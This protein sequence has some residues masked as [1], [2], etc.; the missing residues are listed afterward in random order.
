MKI[1]SG[2][3]IIIAAL[4]ISIVMPFSVSAAPSAGI[5]PSSIFYFFDTATERVSLFFTFSPEKKA[6]KALEYADERLA[7]VVADESKPKA[8]T[9]AMANYQENIS[10]ATAESKG[11]KDKEKA[12]SLLS[13]IANS[14]SK[15]QEV[16]AK[17][18]N[19]VPDEAK[20]AIEKAIE[21]SIKG[22]E[23]ALKE[24]RGLKKTVEELQKD[25]ETL[26]QHGQSAQGKEI[27]VLRK[28]VETLKSQQS[29]QS[30]KP[31]V[32][33]KVIEKIIEV[34]PTTS[35]K[36]TTKLSNSEIIEKVKPAVVYIQT[37]DGSG[38][39]MII[40]SNGYVLTNAHVVNDVNTAK[41]KLSDGRLF[42]G[43]VT[44]RDEK[45]D[46]ALLKIQNDNL[47]VVVLGDSSINI[48]KQGDEVFTLG[49][50]FGLE[51]DV[52]FKEGTIS[53]RI[54]DSDTT[55][56]ETSAEIHPGNSGG[57]LVNKY[58]EV[59]GINTANYGKSIKGIAIGE[60]IKFALP[61]NLVRGLI[62]EL[63]TGRNVV[64]PTAPTTQPIPAPTP[65][66]SP[67]TPQIV[68]LE[69]ISAGVVPDVTSARIEWQTN[70]P[71]NAKIFISGKVY[72]SESGL[73]TRHIVNA[74]DLTSNTT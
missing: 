31:Q 61:I 5:K 10:L 2:K 42:I 17:V 51:G 21:I 74:K 68:A 24:A 52:S 20:K 38:S 25:I 58:G 29:T 23:E 11:I 3:T 66:L 8:V 30:A 34:P 14:T 15:H 46:L 36:S 50:P 39:G 1:Q 6:R 4:I 19:K 60:T 16:L 57:P 63:K 26:K 48:L 32:I 71:T 64:L 54:S 59:I 27:E 55:Y 45:M 73:S 65:V 13:T 12:E 44:G 49:Y 28:E 43:S 41:I 37:S 47:P 72:N 67:V 22:H 33:E 70:K 7:E 40:E 9:M 53:R 62:P 18:Y 69:I 35:Q 56:L